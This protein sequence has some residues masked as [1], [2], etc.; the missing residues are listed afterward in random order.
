M[1]G[2]NSE[3]PK[4]QVKKEPTK[5]EKRKAELNIIVDALVRNYSLAE[6]MGS[7]QDT[8]EKDEKRKTL[9]RKRQI[10]ALRVGAALMDPDNDDKRIFMIRPDKPILFPPIG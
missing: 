1:S 10:R 6:L 9:L 2:A 4:E 5:S 8:I 3:A 7:I